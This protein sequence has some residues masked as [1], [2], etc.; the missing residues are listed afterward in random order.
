MTIRDARNLVGLDLTITYRDRNGAE[1][2]STTFVLKADFVP[3]Y[4]PCLF[5]NQ[6]EIALDR[7]VAWERIGE[8]KAA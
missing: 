2:S 3:F 7:I 5:T 8:T 6:G 4:G 1:T